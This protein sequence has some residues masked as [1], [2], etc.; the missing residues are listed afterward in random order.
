MSFHSL[1][2]ISRI[3]SGRNTHIFTVLLSVIIGSTH[4]QWQE[5]SGTLQSNFGPGAIGYSSSTRTI[6][7]LG[8]FETLIRQ[9]DVATETTAPS[10]T[11]FAS[12]VDQLYGYA[13]FWTSV[14]HYVYMIDPYEARTFIRFDVDT[15]TADVNYSSIQIPYYAQRCYGGPY[16]DFSFHSCLTSINV[17]AVDY[18]VVIGGAN[19]GGD[20]ACGGWSKPRDNTQI[21]SLADFQWKTSANPRLSVPRRSSACVTHQNSNTIYVIG[22]ISCSGDPCY[23]TVWLNTVQFLTINDMS[24]IQSCVWNTLSDTL[25]SVMP[26]YEQPMLEKDTDGPRALVVGTEIFVFFG[27]FKIDVIDTS[28]KSISTRG[29]L[30]ADGY[31]SAFIIAEDKIWMVRDNTWWTL[32]IGP[33]QQPTSAPTRPPTTLSS[34]PTHVPTRPPTTATPTQSP[35][36]GTPTQTPSR[37]PTV[38]TR[39]PTQTPSE[40]PTVSPST[41]PTTGIPTQAPSDAPTTATPT[42]TPSTVPSKTPSI[43]PSKTP[44]TSPSTETP[45]KTPSINPSKTPTKTPSTIPS[46]T[47]SQNPSTALPSASPSTPAPSSSPVTGTPSQNPSESPVTT[48]FPSDTPSIAPIDVFSSTNR[49]S[50]QSANGVDDEEQL[51]YGVGLISAVVGFAICALCGQRVYKQRHEID[52]E[53]GTLAAHVA[54]IETNEHA[55]T[56]EKHDIYTKQVEEWNVDDVYTWLSTVSDGDLTDLAGK[57]KAARI[58]GII[59]DTL[60]DEHL[61]EFDVKFGEKMEFNLVRE[62]LFARYRKQNEDTEE[63]GHGSETM[64]VTQ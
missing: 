51:A 5:S 34:E 46:K 2:E 33:T 40:T 25:S 9:I 62:D 55:D 18:L 35:T 47:P 10:S 43:V 17:G 14:D 11:T 61:D 1:L 26:A 41:N 8:G 60:R 38:S 16:E 15:G 39:T 42:K 31:N 64:H 50:D 44:T 29:Q 4:A 63:P 56:D 12:P 22:G 49:D 59:L 54:D 58:R 37:T 3:P 24:D 28:T 27:W 7:L 36:T 30:P 23:Q 48:R 52:D 13:Q 19:N 32:Y 20:D 6:W 45:T 57:F 21:L 53:E